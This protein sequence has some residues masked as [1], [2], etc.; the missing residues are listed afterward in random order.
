M[1]KKPRIRLI[2]EVLISEA[3]LYIIAHL[4]ARPD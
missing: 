1:A 4:C 2:V 3:R